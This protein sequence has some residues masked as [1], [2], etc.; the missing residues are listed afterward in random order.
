MK[1]TA[2]AFFALLIS[3]S[4]AAGTTD[5]SVLNWNI[6]RG[7]GSNGPNSSEQAYLAKTVNYL[8]PAIWTINELG[9]NNAGFNPANEQNALV[10]FISGSITC[11]GANPVLNKDY[12]VYVGVNSDGFIGNAIVSKYQLTETQTFND[13]LRGLTHANALLPNGAS[14]GIFTEHLK[15]TTNSNNSTSDS[16]QRQSEAEQTR[17]NLNNWK[18]SHPGAPAVMTGDFNLSEDAGEDDNWN[19]GNIG[20]TLPN[21]HIYAPISTIKSAGFLDSKPLSANGDPDTISSGSSNPRTRFD[22]SLY[23]NT[24]GISYVGGTVFNTAAYPLNGRPAGFGF[25]DSFFAS[26]HLA[27]LATYRVEAVPEPATMT[28]LAGSLLI[29][30]QRSK[31][32]RK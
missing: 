6:R 5:V 30:G 24:G 28:V 25:D 20:G 22:Y 11:F 15:A 13:G 4:F 21:G 32:A 29:L 19:A 12:Y 27:V 9:G 2:T 7:I 8:K 16:Q 31:R 23:T 17:N 14:L 10:S 1:L 18:L 3:Q 26:D